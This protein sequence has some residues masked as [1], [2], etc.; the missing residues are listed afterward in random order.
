MKNV[1]HLAYPKMGSIGHKVAKYPD[2]QQDVVLEPFTYDKVGV[3]IRSH[4]NNFLDLE[5]IICATKALRNAGVKRIHLYVPYLLGARSDRQFYKG[6]KKSNNRIGTSYLRDVI[7]PIINLLEFKSVTVFDPHSSVMDAVIHNLIAVDNSSLCLFAITEIRKNIKSY[8]NLVLIAPDKGAEQKVYDVANHLLLKK[9]ITASKIRELDGTISQTE[10]PVIDSKDG[11]E[12]YL[13]ID[14]I[15][16]GGRTFI[17]IAKVLRN[18]GVNVHIYL[19]VTHGIFSAGFTELSK[20]FTRI[21]TTN[22]IYK[23]NVLNPAPE[24]LVV[25]KIF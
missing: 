22:S 18:Q 9:V 11:T 19:I 5:L 16:D 1:L 20:Y 3:E 8:D 21:F 24:L 4:M 25:Q 13:L 7:A 2:G 23:L 14:D 12:A 6:D 17:E 15:C 10:L